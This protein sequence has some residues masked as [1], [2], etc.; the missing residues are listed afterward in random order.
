MTYIAKC[1]RDLLDNG[2]Q[3]NDTGYSTEKAY[4]HLIHKVFTAMFGADD[5]LNCGNQ[6]QMREITHDKF[7]L[8]SLPL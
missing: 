8:T 7:D 6:L 3:D 5:L 4:T 1:L 2:S